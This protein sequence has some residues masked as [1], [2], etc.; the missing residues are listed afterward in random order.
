MVTNLPHIDFTIFQSKEANELVILLLN[1]IENEQQQLND[2]KTLI[3]SLK[4]EINRLNGEQGKP[5]IKPNSK[6]KNNNF[7]T[8]G[9]E[10]EKKTHKKKA[11]KENIPVDKTEFIDYDKS[12]LPD[13][14]VFKFYDEV[15]T[16]NVILKRENILYKIAVY[17]SPSKN[18]IYRFKVPDG[19]SYHSTDL[20]SFII[21]QN[22]VCDVTNKKLLTM[23]QSMGIEISAGSLSNIILEY[24]EHRQLILNF[25]HLLILQEQLIQVVLL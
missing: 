24:K 3:Q 14:A 18:K 15:I 22:K 5:D 16:Q 23:L 20:K 19:K 9:K 10:K 25:L 1:I 12:K 4:D 6:P 17:Y 7:S 8:D 13:D 2:Q 21:A 11:K